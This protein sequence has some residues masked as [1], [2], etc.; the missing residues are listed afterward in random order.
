MA[1]VFNGRCLNL[2]IDMGNIVSIPLS[3]DTCISKGWIFSSLT[4]SHGFGKLRLIDAESCKGIGVI[5]DSEGMALC[6]GFGSKVFIFVT[7]KLIGLCFLGLDFLIKLDFS[8]LDL[9]YCLSLFTSQ[10]SF[11]FLYRAFFH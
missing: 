2:V 9:M 7:L 1:T 11:F 5:L 4:A 10:P 8:D 3:A 6:G